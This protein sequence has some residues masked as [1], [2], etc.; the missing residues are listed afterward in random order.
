M[1]KAEFVAVERQRV[2]G[3]RSAPNVLGINFESRRVLPRPLCCRNAAGVGIGKG[4]QTLTIEPVESD[5]LAVLNR[6][7]CWISQV[8][9]VLNMR[10]LVGEK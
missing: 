4:R 2:F 9:L 5:G 1:P 8:Q 10:M 3:L 6:G 7:T